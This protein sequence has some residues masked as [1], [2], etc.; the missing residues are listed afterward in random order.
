VA[1]LFDET[2]GGLV[3]YWKTVSA[4]TSLVGT[5]SAAQIAP[6]AAKQSWTGKFIVYTVGTS[7]SFRHLRG[8]TGARSS[9][10]HIYCWADSRSAADALLEVVKQNTQNGTA[11]GTWAGTYINWVFVMDIDQGYDK[12]LDSSTA[13][14]YWSRLVLRIVHSESGGT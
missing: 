3:T 6:D 12:P 10:V 9:V 14:K 1:G 7:D 11:R 4:I 2:S 8:T 13:N 5:G